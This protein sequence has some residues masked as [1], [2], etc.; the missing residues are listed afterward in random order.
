MNLKTYPLF[1]YGYEID[2]TNNILNFDEG[3]GELTATI[4]TG[5]YSFEQLADAVKQAMDAASTLTQVYFVSAVR[6]SQKFQITSTANFDL[7]VSSGTQAGVGPWALMGFTGSDL[8]GTNAYIGNTASGSKYAPQFLLQDF[9]SPDQDVRAIDSSINESANG[10]L[11]T[12]SFGSR[13]FMSFS[14]KFITDQPTDGNVIRQNPSGEADSVLFLKSL[15]R[16]GPFEIMLDEANLN[17][18]LTLI[19]ESTDSDSKGTGYVLKPMI[20]NNLPDYYE[21]GI[22]KFRVVE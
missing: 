12:V 21:T 9:L 22:M 8:T 15:I 11:Q 20:G 17:N 6:S 2:Q 13:R 7:L 10:D 5:S 4:A 3:A 1:Y 18:Y 19:L 14:L 16:K